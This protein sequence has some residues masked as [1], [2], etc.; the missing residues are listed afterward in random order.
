MNNKGADQNA[1]LCRLICAF[2]V[3]MWHNR[4]SP[5]MAHMSFG[6]ETEQWVPVGLG[7]FENDIQ[8]H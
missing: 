4:F 7:A 5:D 1:R 2:V 6:R 8:I 3:R